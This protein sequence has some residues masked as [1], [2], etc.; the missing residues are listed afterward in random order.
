MSGPRLQNHAS[1][2]IA[3]LCRQEELVNPNE[4]V[5]LVPRF[6]CS[7]VPVASIHGSI[8]VQV[9]VP[10][11][12]MVTS[13]GTQEAFDTPA[14]NIH[15]HVFKYSEKGV[16]HGYAFAVI[17]HDLKNVTA[18]AEHGC[19]CCHSSAAP[20]AQNVSLIRQ[21]QLLLQ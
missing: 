16:R 4:R 18:F 13:T 21:A 20:C 8:I 19:E 6:L 3:W 11:W 9:L 5:K 7:A 1:A 12:C 14:K 15:M 17:F 2:S 10:L